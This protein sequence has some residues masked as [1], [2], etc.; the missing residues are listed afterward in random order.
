MKPKVSRREIKTSAPSVK[1]KRANY[2]KSIKTK[3]CS[4]S[5]INRNV[6]KKRYK[7]PILGIKEGYLTTALVGLKRIS[8][9]YCE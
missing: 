7:S 9:E 1:Q 8:T 2:R 3:C 5:M 6:A 4:F